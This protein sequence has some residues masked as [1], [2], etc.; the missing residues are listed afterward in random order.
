[1]AFF[2][3]KELFIRKEEL[4]TRMGMDYAFWRQFESLGIKFCLVLCF[5]FTKFGQDI[6]HLI[7]TLLFQMH[8]CFT[9]PLRTQNLHKGGKILFPLI[10]LIIF[11]CECQLGWRCFFLSFFSK[12]TISLISSLRCSAK[13]KADVMQLDVGGVRFHVGTAARASYCVFSMSIII[14]HSCYTSPWYSL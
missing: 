11:A 5:L 10:S 3:T 9:F 12:L 1:M 8:F 13:A 6:F 7:N 4:A 2:F 14:T